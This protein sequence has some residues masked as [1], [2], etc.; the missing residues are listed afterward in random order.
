MM[1]NWGQQPDLAGRHV[2]VTGAGG[3]IG[4]RAVAA[5]VAA[6]AR[7]TAVLRSGHE[8]GALARRGAEVIRAPLAAIPEAAMA[9]DALVHLAYDVRAPARDNLAGFEAMVQQAEAAGVGRIVHAS[10]V[11]VH[12]TWPAGDIS[13]AGPW[14]GPGGGGYRQ[15]KIAMERRLLSGARPAV[16]LEPTIVYGP[17]SSLWTEAPMTRLKRGPVILPDPCGHCPAVHVDDVAR[18]IVLAV[19]LDSPG[20]ER[21]IITGPDAP[22]WRSFY[23]GYRRILGRGEIRQLA[24]ARIE[25][26]LGPA[27]AGEGEGAGPSVAARISAFARRVL[28][29]RRFEALVARAAALRGGNREN[30]PD[31]GLFDLYRSSP[32][33]SATAARDRLGFVPRIGFEQGLASIRDQSR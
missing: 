4:R 1:D 9:A 28:G 5:L 17:G 22:D 32:R 14:G 27:P 29:N 15:A 10:S 16:I 23:E 31:R 20:R 30:W 18:A 33:V 11:V 2:L 26:R 21:F 25:A 6:G 3:F 13:E 7:V 12:D 24:A 8:A 19:A